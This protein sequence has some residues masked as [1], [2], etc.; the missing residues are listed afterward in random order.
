M[1]AEEEEK[2]QGERRIPWRPLVLLGVII[3][4]LVLSSVLGI[5]EKILML[6]DW[7]DT[8]GAAKHIVFILLYVG[9]TVAALPGTVLTVAAGALFGSVTGVIVVSVAST[10]GASLSFLIARYFARNSVDRWLGASDRFRRLDAMTEK[11]GHIIVAITRLVPIFPFNFLNYAFGLTRVPFWTY[12]FWSWLC[13]LP[14]TILYVVGTDAVT[15]AVS[16]K[17]IP[18]ALVVAIAAIIVILT[19]LVRQARKALKAEAERAAP[20]SEE[21]DG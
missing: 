5:G 9:A 6:R 11:H 2:P 1:N 17:R 21:A 18:W 16:E 13:M 3:V 4:I 12:V 15:T 14:G 7:I 19:L 8:L 10:T 20:Q